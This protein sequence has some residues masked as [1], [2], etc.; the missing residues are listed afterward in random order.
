[1]SN[2]KVNGN[3]LDNIFMP[4]G[5]TGATG[6]PS[7][8]NFTVGGTDLQLR[9]AAYVPNTIAAPPT[10]YKS[11][12]YSNLD[13]NTVFQSISSPIPK[14]VQT[15]GSVVESGSTVTITWS[16][17]IGGTL[18][19]NSNFHI[20]DTSILISSLI[21]GGSG[22]DG[23]HN[24]TSSSQGG[25]GGNGGKAGQ[26]RTSVSIPAIYDSIYT[27]TAGAGGAAGE[28]NGGAGGAG[29]TS[30]VSVTTNTQTA[31]GDFL[32]SGAG[33]VGGTSGSPNG[34]FGD[35]VTNSSG[36]GGGGGA[37]S[38]QQNA[39]GASTGGGDGGGSGGNGSGSPNGAAPMASEIG[40]AI[41][42]GGGG[43]GGGGYNST[44]GTPLGTG[45]KGSK[46]RP[47]IVIITFTYP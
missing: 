9:Y 46:G 7:A 30:I 39:G 24:A 35:P 15:G 18:L 12:N 21:G 19:L 33:G 5:A 11:S 36:G 1:M 23:G 29:G 13:L 31:L 4:R 34:G 20:T 22:G 2:F 42:G 6:A 27:I 25:S 3:D 26:I 47:G 37:L 40:T 41:G 45:A 43:G 10:H 8:T 17:G 32:A 14:Y 16:N 44:S 28:S 38:A